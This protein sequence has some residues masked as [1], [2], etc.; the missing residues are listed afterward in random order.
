[1]GV[2]R[3]DN[4]HARCTC[5]AREPSR[6]EGRL[7]QDGLERPAR[8]ISQL[9]DDQQ[10]ARFKL[11]RLKINLL[12]VVFV[13]EHPYPPS[14]APTACFYRKRNEQSTHLGAVVFPLS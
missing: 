9:V 10:G 4:G 1:M 3:E 6:I 12:I 11:D 2:V 14:H 13:S 5:G 8:R 7:Q